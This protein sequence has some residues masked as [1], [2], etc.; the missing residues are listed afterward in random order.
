[1]RIRYLGT[2]ASEGWPGLYC[3]CAYCE[4][5]RALGGKNI[6]TRAQAILD[7]SL[8]IDLCPDTYFHMLR[9]GLSMP[10]IEHV[11]ITHSHLDHF[12][13]NEISYRR[14]PFGH[15]IGPKMTLYGNEACKVKFDAVV[16]RNK[17]PEQLLRHIEYQ[18]V[19]EF[20]PFFAG[21]SVVTPLL[22][23]HDPAERCLVYLIEKDEKRI[24][25]GHDSG[26]FPEETWAHLLG[27]RCDLITLEGTQ[28]RHRD[29][30]L[31]MGFLD[32]AEAKDRLIK[33]GAADSGTQ[34]VLTHLSH[35]GEMMHDEC[36]AL[37]KPYGLIV[38]YDGMILDF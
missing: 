2:G 32:A 18:I 16:A 11:L 15:G 28:I 10:D 26:F 34:F 24:L 3:H 27:K 14:E 17:D 21:S 20:I 13:P 22:A 19:P 6:R 4:K 37:A 5:A 38:A 9:D 33:I 30:A 29:G 31:H 36:V 25:H 7:E 23:Q 8:L 1:M 12:T 35:N